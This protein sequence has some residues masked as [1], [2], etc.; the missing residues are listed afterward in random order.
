ML[1]YFDR[2]ILWCAFQGLSPLQIAVAVGLYQRRLPLPAS[3]AR[4]PPPLRKLITACFA[5]DPK[6]RPSAAEAAKALSL[7]LKQHCT[8][9][10]L[11]PAAAGEDS[12]A[13]DAGDTE[14]ADVQFQALGDAL[15]STLLMDTALTHTSMQSS[16]DTALT[17]DAVPF[18]TAQGVN[19]T[20][21]VTAMFRAQRALAAVAAP[22]SATARHRDIAGAGEAGEP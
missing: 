3:D 1:F 8:Y 11:V 20:G 19:S 16:F 17:D 18:R 12:P 22:G 6:S 4:C 13:C 15:L 7:M 14:H 2:R 10:T 21:G 9:N 5:R